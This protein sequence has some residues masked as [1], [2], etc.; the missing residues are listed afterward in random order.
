MGGEMSAESDYLKQEDFLCR[1]AKLKE[2][3]AL[4]INP[5]P[6]AFEGADDVQSV[7]ERFASQE[8]GHSEDAMERKTPRVKVAGRLVLF[9]CMGKNIFGQLLDNNHKIQ[10]MFNKHFST[11]NGL[12][13]DA[14]ISPIKFIEKKLDLG[15]ILGIEGFLF[16]TQLGELTI[17]VEQVT[18]LTKSLMPLPDKH[19][20]L[21]NKETRYRKRWLDLISSEHVRETFIKRSLI[22]KWIRE[23]MDQ[24]GFMEVETP[25]LQTIYGGAEATPFTT[26]LQALHTEMFLRISLEIALKKLLVGGATRV[27]EI[28]KVF[29]NEGIDR[30]HNPEFTMIE[31]Y[32]AYI[33][34]N[35]VMVFVENLVEY[36]VKKVNHGSTVITYSHLKDGEKQIDLKAPWIRM[37]MKDSI[38]VYGGIDIDLHG[39]HE[40]RDILKQR[41]SV[42]E[43]TLRAA[44]RGDLI[45]LLFDEFVCEHLIS[46]HHI[47]DHPIETTPLCKTLRSGDKSLVER[48]ESFCLGKELCNAYSELNDPLYQRKLLEQQ[49]QK[50]ASQPD[51]EYHPMDEE[52]L[53]ALC[54]GMPPAGGF[55]I[56]IDRLVMILTNSSS[57]RDVLYFPLMRP[58]THG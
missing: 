32:A 35:A 40:L 41:A 51:S 21:S 17:L 34:Y 7:R 56:G 31:A 12:S 28:G 18:L 33:D 3:L 53:E 50:K 44:S 36:V 23:Y 13:P 27:Y 19:M 8:I 43:D 54:Q 20:G 2:I 9:R 10:I 55:G 26:T 52:F 48:F 4:G 29:R 47:T 49:L 30:T 11:V 24:H 5:Y 1:N 58:Q 37:T 46:P 57:I 39:D 6:Y 14:E 22:I 38:K 25:I 42:P 15:D 16:F 45:A